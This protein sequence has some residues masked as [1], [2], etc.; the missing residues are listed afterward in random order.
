MSKHGFTRGVPLGLCIRNSRMTIV[1]LVLLSVLDLVVAV[2]V[3]AA[4]E[5]ILGIAQGP[6][7]YPVDPTIED[8]T[9]EKDREGFG[10]IL[11]GAMGFWDLY[12]RVANDLGTKE[13]LAIDR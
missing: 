11:V 12:D 3:D 7:I 5:Y 8:T 13:Y 4:V 1:V 6:A 9:F 2:G 10:G